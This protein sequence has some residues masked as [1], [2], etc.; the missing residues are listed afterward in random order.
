[1]EINKAKAF[2]TVAEE[3]NFGRAAQRLHMAQPPLSRLIQ[4]LETELGAQLFE[5][6]TRGVTLTAV[7]E[8][9]VAPVRELVMQSERID[10]LARRVQQ[11]ET[12]RVRLGFAGASV[13]AIISELIHR[14]RAVR[15][16]LTFELSGSLLSQPG[17][18]RL[19]SGA[20]DAVVGRWDTVP[21]E[22]DSIVIAQ[23]EL[24]VALPADHALASA[25]T[26]SAADVAAEPWI[27]LPGGGGSTLSNRLNSLAQQGKFIPHIVATA[28]DSP[29][30]LL[31]VDAGE[32]IA[33]TFSGVRNNI[34][35][36]SVV[37]K[38]LAPGLGPVDV[39]LAWRASNNNPALAAVL[40]VLRESGG[41]GASD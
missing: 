18:E 23:E 11:G 19:A 10:Q 2:L 3:L 25:E 21:R 17:M 33:L 14:V 6:N 16:D 30:Q 36:H 31:R 5:R 1:M 35:V 34:P 37:F 39:R 40:S 22:I 7:G 38:P 8:A 29:T 41:H 26:I 20:L 15:P 28:I 4:R 9:L 13:N 32:G 12:G 27:V 24:L